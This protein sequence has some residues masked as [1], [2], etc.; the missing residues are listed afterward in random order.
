M[1]LFVLLHGA[2]AM[3]APA[4]LGRMGRRAFMIL[5]AMPAAAAVYIASFG[6]R[7]LA[8][9]T[10]WESYTWV[11]RLG[12]NID[13]RLDAL[14]WVMALIVTV[15]GALVLVYSSGYFSKKAKALGRFGG[16]FVAFAGAMLGLVTTDSTLMMYVFW[17]LTTVFSFMLIGHY[18]DRQSSRR[19]ATQAITV[20]TLGGLAM[21]AGIIAL[22]E[23]P[24]G[25]YS[26]SELLNGASSPVTNGLV[27]PQVLSVVMVLLLLGAMTKSALIPFHFWLPAAMAAPTPVSAY[28][29]AAAMVKAGV[30]LVARLTPLFGATDTWHTTTLVFGLATMILG[31]YRALRQ[32]DLK[33]VLAFGT[34]SQLGMLVAVIG[35]G[36]APMALAGMALV[37]GHALFKS[38]LFLTVGVIDLSVGTR[39]LRRLSGLGRKMPILATTAAIAVASMAGLPPL[40]GF[41]AK[42][43][44]LTG[45]LQ[46][47][48]AATGGTSADLGPLIVFAI[49]SVITFAYGVRFWFGAFGTRPTLEPCIPR[50]RSGKTLLPIVILTLG[51]I[52]FGLMPSLLDIALQPYAQSL[53]GEPGH[54]VLWHGF[55]PALGITGV[56][57]VLGLL[58]VALRKPIESLQG[59]SNLPSA[60]GAFRLTLRGLEELATTV[61]ATTQRGSLPSYLMVIL[62]VTVVGGVL[63]G[64]NAIM[65]SEYTIATMWVQIPIAIVIVFAAFLAARSRRRLKA[66]ILSGVSGYAVAL[67]YAVHGGPDIALTQVMVETISLIIFVLVLRRLPTYFTNR[68][69][70]SDRWVRISIAAA[71]GL[72]SMFVVFA[73]VAGRVDPAVSTRLPS[74]TLEYGYGNNVVNVTLVDTRAWDTMGEISVVLVS[75]TG[76]ASLLFV[77]SRSAI[78]DATRNRVTSAGGT[79]W[80]D[81]GD[82]L[83]RVLRDY[84]PSGQSEHL[85]PWLRGA[86][87]LSPRRRSLI[88]EVATRMIFPSM[89]LFSLYLL[90][91]GHNQPGGGFAGGLMAGT[92]LVVR[93]LVGGRYELGEAMR[94]QPSHLLGSGLV[95]AAMAAIVPVFFGGSPLQ[96]AVFDFQMPIYGSVH[97]ATA[98]FFDTGVYLI[99]VGLVLDILRSLGAEVDRHGELEGVS[100]T[101]ALDDEEFASLAPQ[102]VRTRNSRSILGSVRRSITPRRISKRKRSGGELR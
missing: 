82:D 57:V 4:L 12:L 45:F 100:D 37:V 94:L 85:Q 97:M 6:P 87:T 61:T 7:V 91:A 101:Q 20:T 17:E 72:F 10:I 40:L 19:A 26:F 71:T 77:R 34:V 89:M 52:T 102:T 78:V 99:V 3:L 24:G 53:P 14:S 44:A 15:V 63:A 84:S 39:D 35:Y 30:Y 68:P 90:F 38:T 55:T 74:A 51:T 16:S 88:F 36:T 2:A 75:A 96:T 66:V 48:A 5:A 33:L 43:G 98:I 67:L 80:E 50:Y 73:A 49:G 13:F 42:E 18:Y 64:L 41:V 31:G 32:H 83:D 62:S 69:F 28:L 93:Y 22:G 23:M 86:Q 27:N 46:G 81:R 58:L 1:F 9:E 25:S 60:D 65:P 95:L 8:G 59:R 21:L 70:S 47:T 29:H 76:V 56:V 92:A 11:P 54:L 79:V